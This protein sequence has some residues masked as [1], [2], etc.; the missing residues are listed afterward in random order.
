MGTLGSPLATSYAPVIAGL[1][2][3]QSTIEVTILGKI[4]QVIEI[5][6]PDRKRGPLR[7]Q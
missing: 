5:L 1:F 3:V 2:S 7:C 4:F 6:V